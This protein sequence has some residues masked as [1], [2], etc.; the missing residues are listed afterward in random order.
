MIRR[1]EIIR[2]SACA[3]IVVL[4]HGLAVLALAARSEDA[5]LEAGA[6]VVLVELAPL[7]MAPPAPPSEE[8]PGPLQ[9]QSESEQRTEIAPEKPPEPAERQPQTPAPEPVVTLPAEPEPPKPPD[10]QTRQEPTPEVP[11]PTAPPSVVAP[12]ERPAAPAPGRIVRPTSAALVTWQ[13][14]LAAHLDR[15][16]R[17]P[18]GA[19]GDHGVASLAFRLDRRGRVL[20][21]RIVRSS[22][23]AVLDE[24]A[25]ALIKHAQPLPA[26]PGDVADDQLSFVVPLRY[27]AALQR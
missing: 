5:E 7:A 3:G 13:R 10:P 20:A 19:R 27:G 23:S 17:Y 21:S 22:G 8:A 16:K 11:V 25:L 15:Y 12:A 2:W 18:P 1:L 26:P 4:G 6:P 9:A 24:A 14:R